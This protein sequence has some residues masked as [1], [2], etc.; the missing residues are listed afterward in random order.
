MA[1]T[2]ADPSK[3]GSPRALERTEDL[4][5]VD[6][7]SIVTSIYRSEE[8]IEEFIDRALAAVSPFATEVKVIVV[9]DG[10]PDRSAEIVRDIVDRDPRVILVQLSRNFGHHRALI[11]GLEKARG[12]LVLL[13]DSDLEEEPEHFGA[14]FKLMRSSAADAVYGVQKKRKGNW[15]ERVSGELF[16]D[17]FSALSEIRL[18][19]NVSTLRLMRRLIPLAPV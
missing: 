1:S 2:N 6:T 4:Q 14:M 8:T 15:L 10:S 12:E 3:S 9:D 7:I 18:P 13:I 11:A 19:R 17:I 16:Y 5:T